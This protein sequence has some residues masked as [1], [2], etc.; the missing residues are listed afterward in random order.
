MRR[1]SRDK[2]RR[3][4]WRSLVLWRLHLGRCNEFLCTKTSSRCHRCRRR[5]P[6]RRRHRV[7]RPRR[8]PC[9]RR[10]GRA[11]ASRGLHL[12]ELFEIVVPTA[13]R[14]PAH[15]PG[16]LPSLTFPMKWM[17]QGWGGEKGRVALFADGARVYTTPTRESPAHA[18]VLRVGSD[19][20]HRGREQPRVQVR[21]VGSGG[22]HSITITNFAWSRVVAAADADLAAAVFAQPAAAA[23]PT[24]APPLSP[25][26]PLPPPHRPRRR[27]CY[28]RARHPRRRPRR[29]RP[30]HLT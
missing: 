12:I 23:Q 14:R 13:A 11:G 22:G 15:C 10:L 4:G 3:L 26:S 5:R 20:A 8:R 25:P 19:R 1:M 18:R 29:S 21:V 7:R 30:A 6:T 17:D 9:R 27:R 28:R 16:Q 2:L 24:V